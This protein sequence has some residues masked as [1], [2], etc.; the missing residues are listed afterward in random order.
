[1]SDFFLLSGIIKIKE[2]VMVLNVFNCKICPIYFILAQITKQNRTVQC[3]AVHFVLVAKSG[4]GYR[5]RMESR[6][7]GEVQETKELI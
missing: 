2:L 3:S 1:M 6:E 7:E 5:W 4:N